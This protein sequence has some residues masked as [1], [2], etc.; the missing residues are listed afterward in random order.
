LILELLH[1][2]ENF[3]QQCFRAHTYTDTHVTLHTLVPPHV[4]HTHTHTHTHHTVRICS[5]G[6]IEREREMESKERPG[7]RA[8]ERAQERQRG[9]EGEC[10]AMR[11]L[12]A[13][14]ICGLF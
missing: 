5:L 8:R 11:G 13:V 1:S 2:L 9:R 14:W 6:E 3:G 12:A 4:T 7:E 10:G